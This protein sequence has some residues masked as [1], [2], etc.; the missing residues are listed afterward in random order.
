MFTRLVATSIW[1]MPR[2][3]PSAMPAGMILAEQ[4]EALEVG[5]VERALSLRPDATT[6]ARKVMA[7]L[8]EQERIARYG[9][10]AEEVDG[11]DSDEE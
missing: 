9:D 7:T 10:L 8:T 3:M 1:G 11:G 6:A 4:A 2:V 5:D